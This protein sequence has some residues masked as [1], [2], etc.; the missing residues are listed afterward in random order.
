[1]DNSENTMQV[2]SMPRIIENKILER[3]NG[4]ALGNWS[5]SCRDSVE[6]KENYAEYRLWGN[7]VYYYDGREHFCFCNWTSNTTKSRLN[8]LVRAGYF[9]QKNWRI[10]FVLTSQN[11]IYKIDT[12][13]TYMIDNAGTLIE[14]VSGKV[15]APVEVKR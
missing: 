1:M 12:S 13:L 5:L 10:Y 6:K 15:C 7:R 9:F 8:A 4:S 2:Y 14:K 3:L 11:K